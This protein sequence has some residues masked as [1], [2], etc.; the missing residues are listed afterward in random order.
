MKI[1]SD[2]M[3]ELYFTSPWKEMI[4]EFEEKNNPII[5]GGW[6]LKEKWGKDSEEDTYVMNSNGKKYYSTLSPSRKTSY[7]FIDNDK[8]DFYETYS[9]TKY[10]V[11]DK[12]TM[13]LNYRGT[14]E[15]IELEKI[16]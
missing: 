6:N 13:A 16:K 10:D 12:I 8:Y 9:I 14:F 5:S 4:Q 1:M 7:K 11:T 2:K 15:F 3:N